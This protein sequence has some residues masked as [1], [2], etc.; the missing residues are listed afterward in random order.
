MAS[1]ALLDVVLVTAFVVLMR[2]GLAQASSYQS[3]VY[4]FENNSTLYYITRLAAL[5]VTSASALSFVVFHITIAAC[6]SSLQP[7]I[8]V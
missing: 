5:S 4:C 1:L 3:K 7:H 8:V 6:C 2:V